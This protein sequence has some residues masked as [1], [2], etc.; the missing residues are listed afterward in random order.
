MSYLGFPRI[1]F[2]GRL[3]PDPSMVDDDP[4]NVEGDAFILRIGVAS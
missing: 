2:V 1:H 3:R 4:V